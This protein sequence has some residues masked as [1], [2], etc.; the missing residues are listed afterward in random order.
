[1]K[2]LPVGAELFHTDGKTDM[3]KLM[4]VFRKFAIAPKNLW[5]R[6]QPNLNFKFQG[7]VQ[8]LYQVTCLLILLTDL[9]LSKDF[10]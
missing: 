5:L 1:M 3:T 8:P 6:L 4:V 7:T 10:T 2:I 9:G